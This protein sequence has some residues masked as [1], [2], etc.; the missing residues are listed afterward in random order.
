MPRRIIERGPERWEAA[1]SGRR[2]QYTKDEFSVVF[3]RLDGGRVERRI[4]RY[5]PLGVKSREAAFARLSDRDLL[6]LLGRSQPAWT[7]P[8]TGYRR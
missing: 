3:T 5:T 2:T 8:E 4:A 7:A 6:E 1:E